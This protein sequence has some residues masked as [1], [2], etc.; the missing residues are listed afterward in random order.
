MIKKAHF[1]GICGVGMAGTAMLLKE[2]GWKI[3]GS[4]EGNYPPISTYVRKK[5]ISFSFE[6]SK[7]NIPEDV[8]LIVIGRHSK[9]SPDTNE[10]V[11][12]ALIHGVPVKSF[13]E[14]LEELTKE[15]HVTVVA[16][17]HGK[18]TVTALLAWCLLSA[19][20]KP[21]YFIGALT[22]QADGK[23]PLELAHIGEDPQFVIEGDEY[24]T[25]HWD[26]LP[27]FLHYHP[28]DIILTGAEHDHTNVYPTLS[29]YRAQF[30]KLIADMPT[31]GVLTA[32]LDGE[33][34]KELL[35]KS[36]GNIVTYALNQEADFG[37]LDIHYGRE[38]NFSLVQNGSP[39]IRLTTTLLGKHNIENIVG[40]SAYILTKNLM[41]SEELEAGIRTFP[42]LIRRLDLKTH[43]S[44]VLIYE[45]FGSS[46]SKA[47]AAIEALRLHFPEKRLVVVFEPHTFSWRNKETMQWYDTVFRGADRILIY[48]EPS[49]EE[50]A[51][52]ES[53]IQD[54]VSRVLKSGQRAVGAPNERRALAI[55]S[56]ELENNDI[57]LLLTSGAMGGLI[58]SVP[59]LAEQK[60][61]TRT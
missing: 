4:D 58:D 18:S 30:E 7:N 52:T 44:S 21:G 11:Q 28:K 17:N 48:H 34:V 5:G 51:E 46:Y 35:K 2:A 9:L 47:R 50:T 14:I 39:R 41:S 26:T 3:S 8:D 27:K 57:V 32:C 12:A 29:E 59:Q 24:P 49:R 54:I 43:T 36:R 20:K 53:E 13:P 15:R 42:G 45:G 33:N 16:G 23:M 37:A 40:V 61:P 19:G 31:D 1:I 6:Y 60:F 25:S 38:T 56:H 22:G 10:E 55:L